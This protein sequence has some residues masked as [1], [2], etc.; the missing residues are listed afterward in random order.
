M[1]KQPLL[2]GLN[3]ELNTGLM[4]QN[5][6]TCLNSMSAEDTP[7]S[8]KNLFAGINADK[9]TAKNTMSIWANLY[10]FNKQEHAEVR[11][12]NIDTE[13]YIYQR[14]KS[15]PIFTDDFGN[16]IFIRVTD[17]PVHSYLW[18][19]K[20]FGSDNENDF[21]S[22]KLGNEFRGSGYPAQ[23]ISNYTTNV[24]YNVVAE[25]E[26]RGVGKQKLNKP[27]LVVIDRDNRDYI[28]LENVLL[29]GG[30][31]LMSITGIG[32]TT[33]ALLMSALKIG[34]KYAE[35]PDYKPTKAEI[36]DLGS[37]LMP[38]LF[39]NGQ[40][41]VGKYLNDGARIYNNYSTGNYKEIA[42]E[43]GIGQVMAS[44]LGVDVFRSDLTD[45]ILKQ[46]NGKNN[47]EYVNG[48]VQ[49][50]KNMETAKAFG[51]AGSNVGTG[52]LEKS[53]ILT[54]VNKNHT[55]TD[56]RELF[57]FMTIYSGGGF[58]SAL[59]TQSG[60]NDLITFLQNNLSEKEKTPEVHKALIDVG[61]GLPSG[62]RA[63]DELLMMSIENQIV[64]YKLKSFTI[65]AQIPHEKAVCIKKELE[66]Y[67]IQV[68][69]TG[70]GSIPIP[71]QTNSLAVK[72]NSKYRNF[73]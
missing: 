56:S 53:E 46:S 4:M 50:I 44:K 34:M 6:K 23:I 61:M 2:V 72:S 29:V 52:Q 41:G 58:A 65:P 40:S 12:D 32:V 57:N 55:L 35:N 10:G 54:S 1:S 7:L 14:Y 19:S 45:I 62:T 3:D 18:K 16:K 66:K 15:N 68:I 21:I 51:T 28:S 71:T 69:G 20:Y 70:Y 22:F 26:K 67:G 49:Q 64:K 30:A 5:L 39:T 60:N 9:D 37:Q 38:V 42:N 31:I 17:N 25:L 27:V 47:Y 36:G 73:K 59:P 33:G 13:S 11:N 63:F 24:K 8:Y 48:V 43:L